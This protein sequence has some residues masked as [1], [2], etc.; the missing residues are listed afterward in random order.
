MTDPRYLRYE[1]DLYA[2]LLTMPWTGHAIAG[3]LVEFLGRRYIVTGVRIDGSVEVVTLA[4]VPDS[5]RG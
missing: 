3:W 2:P 4:R 1:S 5:P